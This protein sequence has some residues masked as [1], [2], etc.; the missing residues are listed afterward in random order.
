MGYLPVEEG[1]PHT[2]VSDD[3]L[4]GEKRSPWVSLREALDQDQVQEVERR[5]ATKLVRTVEQV[6][7]YDPH[8][9]HDE[10]YFKRL[11]NSASHRYLRLVIVVT[12]YCTP[13]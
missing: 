8:V 9:V 2:M 6:D 3:E 4:L 7:A 11:Q 10:E 1:V 13:G 5:G 12:V